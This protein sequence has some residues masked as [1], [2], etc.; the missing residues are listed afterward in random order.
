VRVTPEPVCV[1][2]LGP[3]GDGELWDSG[4]YEGRPYA[5]LEA[6]EGRTLREVITSGPVAVERALG[7]IAQP[8][9]VVE[10][11]HGQGIEHRDI[12]FVGPLARHT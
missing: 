1:G 7:W 3:P 8:L 10:A 11:L 9:D 2:H 4:S 5:V 6:I 12:M